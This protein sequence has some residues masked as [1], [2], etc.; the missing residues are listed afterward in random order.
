MS[1][2]QTKS[3]RFDLVAKLGQSRYVQ[4]IIRATDE[5]TMEGSER[6]DG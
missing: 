5:K 4:S 3:P 6:I 2:P 1:I